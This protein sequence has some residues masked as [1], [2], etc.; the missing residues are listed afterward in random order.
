[1]TILELPFRERAVLD[2]LHFDDE[3]ATVDRGYAGYG[4]ARVP[5]IWLV[6]APGGVRAAEPI[7]LDDVLVLALHSSDLGEV[8]RDDI[9]LEFEL[10][11]AAP[12]TVLAS[13]FLARWLP[14]LPAARAT[15]LAMC[16]PHRATLR[17]VPEASSP[18]YYA[19]GDVES[20]LDD[21]DAD[22]ARIEL[23]ADGAWAR[24]SS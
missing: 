8:L 12:V 3:R 11:D 20:W 7:V 9:E 14:V 24:L 5:R 16:N 23:C 15:V 1:M 4:W 6:D 19:S 10:D 13:Q 17:P 21:T 18:I 2:L 22:H